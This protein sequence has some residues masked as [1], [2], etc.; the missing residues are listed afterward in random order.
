MNDVK[1]EMKAFKLAY[2]ELMSMSKNGEVRLDK[3]IKGALKSKQKDNK[4]AV[5][6]K[7]L[8]AQ[9][10]KLF[11]FASEMC[12]PAL[13][14]DAMSGIVPQDKWSEPTLLTNLDKAFP[15][16]FIKTGD[17]IKQ[18]VDTFVKKFEASEAR[19]SKGPSAVILWRV[20]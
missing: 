13:R 17:V 16:F 1:D 15:D 4:S 7:S 11:E 19:A 5:A 8:A 20:L 9:S 10:L 12:S 6:S 3:A 2:A 14:N 18:E